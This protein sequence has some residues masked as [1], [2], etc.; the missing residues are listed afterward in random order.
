MAA[1]VK[2]GNA[3]TFPL[4]VGGNPTG[5]SLFT[6]HHEIGTAPPPP[7]LNFLLQE[8]GSFL[9]QEDLSKIIIT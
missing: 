2:N 4:G 3:R 1:G 7:V 6:L 9:L 5:N 8:D